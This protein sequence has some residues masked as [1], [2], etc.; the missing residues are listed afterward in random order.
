MAEGT[1]ALVFYTRYGCSLCEEF[2]AALAAWC[3]TQPDLELR[4]VD[5][6]FDALAEERYGAQVPLVCGDDGEVSRIHFEAW[7]MDAWIKRRRAAQP[8]VLRSTIG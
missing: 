7:R 3:R 6:D 5:V 4:V 8:V 1:H 2:H